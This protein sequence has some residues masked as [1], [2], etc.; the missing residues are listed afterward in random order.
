MVTTNAVRLRKNLDDI[1]NAVLDYDESFK[2]TTSK[3]NAVLIREEGYHSLLET[4]YLLSQPGLLERIKEGEKELISEMT[5][6]CIDTD[7]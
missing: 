3:G 4:L 5:P 7:W 1:L 6:F 2:I